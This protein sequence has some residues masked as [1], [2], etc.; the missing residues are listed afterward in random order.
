MPYNERKARKGKEPAPNG[1][2]QTGRIRAGERV[3]NG[4]ALIRI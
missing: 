4:L 3:K 2:E 1:L